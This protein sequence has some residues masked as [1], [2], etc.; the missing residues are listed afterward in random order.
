MK[1]WRNAEPVQAS[2]MKPPR[3][4][5]K[6]SIEEIDPGKLTEPR[7]S[8]V[9]WD[10]YEEGWRLFN[11]KQFWEAHEVWEAIWLRIAEDSRIFFQ[12]IIQT[13]A[14]FH[15]V[16][17]KKRPGGARRNF[18]KAEAKLSLFPT[19]FLGVNV[20]QLLEI[21]RSSRLELEHKGEERIGEFDRSLPPAV[22]VSRR[23]ING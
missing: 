20:G 1:K 19:T 17:V 10:R 9:D 4:P 15:L 8:A 7:L 23:P 22:P 6:K 5:P 21:I 14:A 12:G 18:E 16:F 13:A 11:E 2:I 3:V